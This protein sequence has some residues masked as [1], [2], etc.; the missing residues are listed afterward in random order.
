MKHG[1]EKMWRSHVLSTKLIFGMFVTKNVLVRCMHIYTGIYERKVFRGVGRVW[2]G[3][4]GMTYIYL[5]TP[6]PIR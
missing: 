3:D 1:W 5:S 6:T 4:Y 2:Y